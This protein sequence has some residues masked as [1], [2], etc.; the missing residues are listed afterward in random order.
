MQVRTNSVTVNDCPILFTDHRTEETHAI[1]S[2]DEW[3]DKFILPLCVS[4]VTLY[5]PVHSLTK[6]EWNQRDT[7]RVTLKNKHLTWDPNL[8]D[9]EDQ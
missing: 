6:N 9:Y 8:V 1:I 3:R 5:F 2:D 4:G 7:P